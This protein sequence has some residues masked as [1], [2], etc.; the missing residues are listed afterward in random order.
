MS[1]DASAFLM[2]A[3]SFYYGVEYVINP[4]MAGNVHRVTQGNAARQWERLCDCLGELADI[5]LVEPA[6]GL[7]D[8]VFTA[9]AGLVLERKAVLSRFVSPR[10]AGRAGP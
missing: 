3:L 2:C 10:T 8:M 7:P 9:N 6:P 1:R 4:W 5:E